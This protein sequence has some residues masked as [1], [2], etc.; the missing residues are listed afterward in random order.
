[1][2][3]P[4]PTVVAAPRTSLANGVSIA[5]TP[6]SS[7]LP[8]S[9]TLTLRRFA[10]AHRGAGVLIT[11]RGDGGAKD[12]DA[13]SQAMELGFKRAAAIATSLGAAGV[14]PPHLKLQADA[15]GTGSTAI[16]N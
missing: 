16:L 1:M 5:F 6:G 13:Q 2:P 7:T 15:L 14:S 10:M 9:A 8:P 4:T 3:P 12:A 11:G